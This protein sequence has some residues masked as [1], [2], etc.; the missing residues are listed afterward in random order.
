MIR[1]PPRSTQ[2]R[3]SA[4]SDVYKRQAYKGQYLQDAC[5]N[6]ES[7]VAIIA[8]RFLPRFRDIEG[9]LEYLEKIVFLQ[10]ADY[11][12]L[13]THAFERFSCVP[14]EEVVSDLDDNPGVDVSYKD[15]A[16]IMY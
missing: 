12:G 3:S 10:E 5:N 13:E 1:R 14:F 4:A 2:S 15:I 6:V 11:A 9:S 7:K 8:E 16:A